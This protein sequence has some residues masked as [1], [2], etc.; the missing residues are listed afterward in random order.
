MR[1][2]APL[3]KHCGGRTR[4]L[5]S[6][7]LV[8]DAVSAS[9]IRSRRHVANLASIPASIQGA[10]ANSCD[11]F[12]S[13]DSS[14][15]SP[16]NPS[17]SSCRTTA[18]RSSASMPRIVRGVS[19]FCPGIA[20]TGDRS[21]AFRL[22]ASIDCVRTSSDSAP[23]SF[24]SRQTLPRRAASYGSDSSSANP[25]SRMRPRAPRRGMGSAPHAPTRDS[26]PTR[27]DSSSRRS[28]C[29]ME[30]RSSSTGS[31]NCR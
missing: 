26:G 2:H 23:K 30:R 24:R 14:A 25:S 7:A 17:I 20:V 4:V 3:G 18:G 28:S 9:P 11:S 12:P 22:K 10:S 5:S 31:R 27:T 13:F 8:G 21:A 15:A 19:R 29:S 1:A 6:T 16:G